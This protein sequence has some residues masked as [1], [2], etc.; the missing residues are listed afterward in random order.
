MNPQKVE[1]TP[2]K[3]KRYLTGANVLAKPLA[4]LAKQSQILKI[5]R[6]DP[7]IIS[8]NITPKKKGNEIVAKSAGFASLYVGT[9]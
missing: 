6:S 8:P 7:C 9:P 1:N 4:G 5:N 3:R 2:I